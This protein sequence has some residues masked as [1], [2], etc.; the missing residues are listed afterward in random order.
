VQTSLRHPD[1]L[2]L[3]APL[4]QARLQAK[5]TQKQLAQLIGEKQNFVSK[6]ETGQRLLDL[7][8]Y[9]TISR[10][11][12]LD[13]L[14]NLRAY[15]EDYARRLQDERLDAELEQTFPASDPLPFRRGT[16]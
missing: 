8:E 5:L 14:A 1:Y 9:I 12:R 13:W 11:L 6:Y 7:L 2:Q 15:D 16:D 10:T 4:K 3:I